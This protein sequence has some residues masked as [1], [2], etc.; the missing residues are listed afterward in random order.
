MKPT[1][2]QIQETRREERAA[3]RRR[4]NA[5]EAHTMAAALLAAAREALDS[6]EPGTT[7]G[8]PTHLWLRS[9]A[10]RE[11]NGNGSETGLQAVVHPDGLQLLP[12]G[13][14]V[15]TGDLRLLTVHHMDGTAGLLD[16]HASPMSVDPVPESAYPMI[17]WS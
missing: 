3:A 8:M 14:H 9:L 11:M 15:C 1:A 16:I 10:A 13:T 5:A 2:K 4:R 7:A 12:G 6:G 17:I